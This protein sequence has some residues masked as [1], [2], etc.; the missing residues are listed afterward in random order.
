MSNCLRVQ[1]FPSYHS[2]CLYNGLPIQ[3]IMWE[4]EKDQE[5][6]QQMKLFYPKSNLL[7]VLLHNIKDKTHN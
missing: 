5:I 6:T 4:K 1:F 7:I 2:N 3:T